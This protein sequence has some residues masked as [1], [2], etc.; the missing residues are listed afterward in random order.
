[1]ITSQ[2]QIDF[3]RQIANMQYSIMLLSD[4]NDERKMTFFT[5]RIS[6]IYRYLDHTFFERVVIYLPLESSLKLKSLGILTRTISSGEN[7]ASISGKSVVI[8]IRMDLSIEVSIDNTMDLEK[9]RKNGFVYVFDRDESAEYIYGK[10]ETRKLKQIPGSTSYFAVQTFKMLEEALEYYR[11]N[12]AEQSNCVILREAWFDE[13]RVF[14][15]NSPEAKLRD[16]LV[17][18]LKQSMRNAEVR[19]EQNVDTSH[20]VDIKISWSLANRIALIE[21]KWLGK[22]LPSDRSHF[23]QDYFRGRA[24]D[25]AKQLSEYLDSNRMQS[26]NFVTKG[27]LVVFD[28][29]RKQCTLQTQNIDMERG[30][31]YK[32]K[33]IVYVPDYS[34]I[35]K[36]FAEPIRF[37]LEP[38]FLI[39]GVE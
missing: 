4:Y 30:L 1:M 36:D 29:R 22:S 39:N 14:L 5:E 13:N 32:V 21:I 2:D 25:G 3:F 10:T 20:P 34:T 23:T 37:F 19:P 24:Q 31:H 27:Y 28:A 6:F 35:R 18:F 8:E 16:S 26:P 12:V 17:S 9:I 33:E 38:K 11:V 15:T 7:L